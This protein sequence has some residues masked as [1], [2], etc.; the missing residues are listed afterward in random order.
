MR[1]FYKDGGS[2]L[3]NI[4]STYSETQVQ[5]SEI[6]FTRDRYTLP[7]ATI[8]SMY[9][10]EGNT[11]VDSVKVDDKQTYHVMDQWGYVQGRSFAFYRSCISRHLTLSPDI[12]IDVLQTRIT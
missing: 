10:A 7:F 4:N 9:V 11:D 12:Q 5:V 2:M 1:I 8:R 6:F 3:L